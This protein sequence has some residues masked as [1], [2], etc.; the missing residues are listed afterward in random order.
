M[1]G[2]KF[3]SDAM[4]R[5]FVRRVSSWGTL[6]G[7]VAMLALVTG[8]P[9]QQQCDTVADC[10]E[11]PCTTVACVEGLCEST[12]LC[13]E[14]E[15]C[16]ADGV[17]VATCS[18]NADCDDGDA[19]TGT[20]TCDGGLCAAGTAVVCNDDVACTDDTCDAG[21]CVFEDNCAAAET[22]NMGTGICEILCTSDGDCPDDG[23]ICTTAI[24]IDGVCEIDNNTAACDDGDVCTGGDACADG[25]CAGNAIA[26]C[27]TVDVTTGVTEGCADTQ[28]CNTDT[29]RCED[30]CVV[31]NDCA[32]D[33]DPCTDETCNAGV[34]ESTFNTSACDDGDLCTS[35]D[36]CDGAGGCAGTAVSCPQDLAC[37][38]VNGNCEAVTCDTNA[39]CDDGFSCTAD[40][41]NVGTKKCV[42]T[43]INEACD[44][45][46]HCTGEEFC[47]PSNKDADA[48]SGC[49]ATGDPCGGFTPICNEGTD[50]CDGCDNNGECDDGFSC[51]DDSCNNDG[52]CSNDPDDSACDDGVFCT[53]NDFC[54]PD[55]DDADANGC[56][57]EGDPCDCTDPSNPCDF[58]V[59][60]IVGEQRKLCN[61]GTESCD[62]CESN[63]DCD[64]GITCT[65]DACN[66]DPGIC[67]SANDDASCPDADFCNGPDICS[68]NDADADAD[69]C[70]PDV[71]N[72]PCS[73]ACNEND[74]SCFNCTGNSD[75]DDGLACTDD[76]C[77]GLD[78]ECAHNDNCDDGFVCNR[79]TGA[80]EE[81]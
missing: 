3:E 23:N 80:C 13:A 27:C 7:V 72:E 70:I 15:G 28:T 45:G 2:L 32:N 41:C 49:W 46:L 24:C 55:H 38:P 8:C 20:E 59:A 47:D 26:G 66:G 62:K 75:C 52:S 35:G 39:D 51:T 43:K 12:D 34:C 19:C 69:G 48:A 56:V 40:T 81:D 18:A 79:I 77:N 53:A 29:N 60:G 54:D 74:E 65:K 42:H 16:N 10:T 44:D 64:D 33:N 30:Q 50:A 58:A 11:D 61:E 78:G 31:D 36:V 9:F 21:T 57:N 63:A 1:S 68:P 67:T 22:C 37:N 73:T 5:A 25:V 4:L 76:L 71:G 6:C 14:G 17:C